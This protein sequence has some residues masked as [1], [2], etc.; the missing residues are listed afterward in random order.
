[1]TKSYQVPTAL[2]A[3][4]LEAREHVAKFFMERKAGP[5]R[6]TIEI[7]GERQLIVRHKR[8]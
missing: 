7:F 8:K 5:A 6:A 4:F 2:E 3:G 1:M